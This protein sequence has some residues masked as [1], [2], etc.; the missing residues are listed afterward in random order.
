[1]INEMDIPDDTIADLE[2]DIEE[3]NDEINGLQHQIDSL[4]ND[5][6]NYEQELDEERATVYKLEAEREELQDDLD[7]A[8]GYI[9]DFVRWLSEVYP[10]AHSEFEAVRKIQDSIEGGN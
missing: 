7:K 4:E 6:F 9:S 1:M 10:N 3:L 8:E 2:K 5:V